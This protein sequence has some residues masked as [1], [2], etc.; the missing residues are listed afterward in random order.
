V[1]N[2]LK[3]LAGYV[4]FWVVC[5]A[6]FRTIFLL[7]HFDG[8]A[9][10][11]E[12][13][14]SNVYG[15]SLDVSTA[16]YAT[17]LLLLIRFVIGFTK[18]K[19]AFNRIAKIY[20]GVLLAMVTLL[21]MI[22]VNLYHVWQS[23]L[24]TLALSYAKYPDEVF[25]SSSNMYSVGVLLLYI[26]V[27]IV[28]FLLYQ[29]LFFYHTIILNKYTSYVTA[30][31]LSVALVIIG[32][33][34][35][36]QNYPIDKSWAYY[37]NNNSLNNASLNSAWNAIQLL[38]VPTLDSNTYNYMTQA[39]CD[40][41]INR[42]HNYITNETQ[43]EYIVNTPKPNV[44]LL[45][46][47]SCGADVIAPLGGEK[48]VTPYFS[49]LCN[50]GLLFT[51]FYSTGFRTDQGLVATLSGFPAQPLTRIIEE[52][53]KFDK[54][55][56]LISS[57][58]KQ[59]YT[60]NY[61]YG[62]RSQFANTSTYLLAAGIDKVVDEQQFV[63]VKRTHW[64]VYDS[65]LFDYMLKDIGES[66]QP[67]FHTAATITSHEEF[68]AK[69]TP[70]FT[71]ANDVYNGYR[72]T[73]RYT[74]SCI[75]NFVQRAKQTKWYA[76]T[77]ILIVADHGHQLPKGR[78][79]NGIEMHHIPFLITGGALSKN[80]KGKTNDNYGSHVAIASTL[81]HQLKMDRKAYTYSKNLIDNTQNHFAYYAHDD[82]FGY[83]SSKNKSI[84]SHTS[85]ALLYNSTPRDSHNVLL[86][87]QA[88][89]Q[90][91]MY[92]YEHVASWKKNK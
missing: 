65:F 41:V 82:G 20:T 5:F 28:L 61:Y 67:F 13:L 27:F 64:G 63:G 29:K 39:K 72:N 84:Y 81:L 37:S 4:G 73:M 49:E 10:M 45:F 33:R 34:G 85:K 60:S 47:E 22:D 19:T 74:D 6:L 68:D 79:Y 21:N 9:S 12:V 50:E 76:N 2:K 42:L 11:L 55:P 83:V 25:A 48:N 87:N 3:W 44:L 32:I 57:F 52:H 58:K 36:V 70:H 53:S 78:P 31:L 54:L 62:G 1:A 66:K 86:T 24:N 75:Y 30:F 43:I 23:K 8:K 35:G 90:K 71:P 38:A 17:A 89:L 40:S 88:L 92:D 80:Y 15:F 59:A 14:C 26:M 69:V 51:N 77:L 16:C 91:I 56:N 46:W 18:F 7:F